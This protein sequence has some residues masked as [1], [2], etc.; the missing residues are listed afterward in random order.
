M[1]LDGGN[2][3]VP[4]Q[5]HRRKEGIGRNVRGPKEKVHGGMARAVI[6]PFP[7]LE[8]GVMLWKMMGE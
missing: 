2:G 1:G 7:A 6:Y 4:S 3:L 8:K 5:E